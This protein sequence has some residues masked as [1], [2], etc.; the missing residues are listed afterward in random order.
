MTLQASGDVGKA[1]EL[2]RRM[3]IV[4]PE[5]QRVLDK[6]QNVPVDINP[7]FKSVETR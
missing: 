2:L 3:A 1:R 5:V 7:I 6:L 4:R